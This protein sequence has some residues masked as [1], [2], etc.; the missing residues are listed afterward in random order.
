MLHLVD[1]KWT[2]VKDKG[3]VTLESLLLGHET[4]LTEST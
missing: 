1:Q 2:Y 3:G 4:A